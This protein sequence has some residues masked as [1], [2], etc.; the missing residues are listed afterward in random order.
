MVWDVGAFM[1]RSDKVG[2]CLVI[3]LTAALASAL[4]WLRANKE[5]PKPAITMPVYEP[6]RV[7]FSRPKGTNIYAVGTIT[8]P[9]VNNLDVDGMCFQ[10]IERKEI[11]IRDFLS[12][13]KKKFPT[14]QGACRL[15][16]VPQ[17]KTRTFRMDYKVGKTRFQEQYFVTNNKNGD[18]PISW[19][20]SRAVGFERKDRRPFVGGGGFV[21]ESAKTC[22]NTPFAFIS[23]F[24]ERNKETHF[25][26]IA[27][28]T[29]SELQSKKISDWKVMRIDYECYPYYEWGALI[30]QYGTG[31][32]QAATLLDSPYQINGLMTYFSN[33]EID[34]GLSSWKTTMGSVVTKGDFVIAK[35]GDHSY[36]LPQP[37]GG[38]VLLDS[39]EDKRKHSVTFLQPPVIASEQ[40]SIGQ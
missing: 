31:H 37:S 3:A 9:G 17:G 8:I 15:I 33:G 27:E 14:A 35:I 26:F 11:P 25:R 7:L 32:R 30:N 2:L 22:I 36:Q 5:E 10:I 34:T 29:A 40:I 1:N 16:E 24:Y 20:F 12:Q 23:Y 19:N 4:V 28:V 13:M 18:M 6:K 21:H 38:S 39:F